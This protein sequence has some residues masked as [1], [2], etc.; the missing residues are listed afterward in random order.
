[1]E[2]PNFLV[3]N[4]PDATLYRFARGSHDIHQAFPEQFNKIVT[5]FFLE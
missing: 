4:I 3:K 1:M 5:D 2:H